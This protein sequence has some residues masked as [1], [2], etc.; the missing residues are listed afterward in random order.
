[1]NREQE[2]EDLLAAKREW[3]GIEQ[4]LAE[5]RA[6]GFIYS[7]QNLSA[8]FK[9]ELIMA[10][11]DGEPVDSAIRRIRP[12]LIAVRS[13]PAGKSGCTGMLFLALL[14]ALPVCLAILCR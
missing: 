4:V 2:I 7:G 12:E 1:M 3:D 8:K 6:S 14:V 13:A 11:R 10:A 5:L 9:A